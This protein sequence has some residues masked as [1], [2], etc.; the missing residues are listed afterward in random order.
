M[1]CEEIDDNADGATG[2]PRNDRDSSLGE[3]P[4]SFELS[5]RVCANSLEEFSSRDSPVSIPPW[6]A[7]RLRGNI[8]RK[9]TFHKKLVGH[10]PI[11]R[12]YPITASLL[13][14]PK[15]AR[16]R[17]LRG[18]PYNLIGVD[19]SCC[20]HQMALKFAKANRLECTFL[21]RYTRY[22]KPWRRLLDRYYGDDSGKMRLQAALYGK[23]WGCQYS[24][25]KDTFE[26]PQKCP[27][28]DT[29]WDRRSHLERHLATVH[30]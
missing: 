15:D 10:E 8:G 26:T 17:L 13:N 9:T 23:Q 22:K 28:C 20:F 25:E 16:I 29:E 30:K 2:F 5:E 24:K 4:P 6:C 27:N 3:S 19:M 12:W 7:N 1:P 18:P 14:V 11:G 21:E